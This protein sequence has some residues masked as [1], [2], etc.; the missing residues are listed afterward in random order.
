[1]NIGFVG[2]GGIGSFY[3]GL[4]TRAG[5]AV[6]LLARGEHLAAIR[7]KGLEVRTP[8]EAFSVAVNATDDS[9]A[10][11]DCEYVFVAVKGYSLAEVAPTLVAAAAKGAA[12]IPLLNG[13]AIPEQLMAFGVPRT[14]IIGGLATVSLFRTAPG[15][16]EQKSP[17][18]RVV[19][20][21]LN[22][23]HSDRTTRLI[24]ALAAVGVEA[25]A[26]DDI[27]LDLWRKFAFIVPITVGCGLSR[28]PA[29]R[30]LANPNGRAL[31]AGA[32]RE[33]VAVSRTTASPLSDADEARL[34]DELFALQPSMR[35]SFL[36]DL[37]AGGRTEVDSL[38]GTVSRLGKEHGVPTPIHD[39]ATAAFEVASQSVE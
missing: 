37:M 23:S 2:A 3:S 31:F 38:A 34:R 20:G 5:H 30:V 19:L 1:M 8:T 22:K 35:P 6:L 28:Q 33:I 10:L 12:I 7:A 13:V 36:V 27:M 17:F 39:V 4:L 18:N 26:S 15:L 9:T 32:L 29:G 11:A 24:D 16:V 25:R 21:E 14:A